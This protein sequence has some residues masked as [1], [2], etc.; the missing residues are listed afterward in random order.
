MAGEDRE[1]G[2]GSNTLIAGHWDQALNAG[3][4]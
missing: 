1:M 4:Y 2:P 3:A